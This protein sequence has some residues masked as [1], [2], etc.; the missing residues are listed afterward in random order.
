VITRIGR[1]VLELSVG[2]FALL[3]FAFVPLGQKTGLE[4]AKAIFS[5]EPAKEAR[6]ELM[7]AGERLRDK[8][9]EPAPEPKA[10]TT[11][12]GADAAPARGEA[13]MCRAP[14][15]ATLSHDAADASTPQ[16]AN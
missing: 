15:L 9:L 13:L 1:R 8:V 5:T 2:V 3:G 14:M 6:R 7:E 4:H 12:A 16:P 10:A 11:D